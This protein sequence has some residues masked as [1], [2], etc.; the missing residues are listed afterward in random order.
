MRR[1]ATAL[2]VV[3]CN[4]ACARKPAPATPAVEREVKGQTIV[5]N[6]LP[7][8]DLTVSD[9]FRYVGSQVVDLYGVADA[10]QHIF[11]TPDTSGPV[12]R[13][14]WFQFEHYLPTNSHTYSYR[15]DR[16]VDVGGL[17]FIYD[18]QGFSNYGGAV[19]DPRSDGAAV[20]ALLAKHHLAVPLRFGRVRMFHLPTA[21]HRSELM[22]IYGEALPAQ[23]R[24]PVSADGVSLDTEDPAAAKL[25]LQHALQG[26]TLRQ[27][28]R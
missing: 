13:V 25:L 23:S 22:I 14:Y 11:T 6:Q 16:T 9:D 24:I 2:L 5:S 21:D 27:H 19:R 10:E 8:A 1:L 7:A 26:L 3:A 15:A 17:Q 12:S 4:V 18:V 20:V 28:V